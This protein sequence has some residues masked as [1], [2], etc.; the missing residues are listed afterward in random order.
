MV[1][2]PTIDTDTAPSQVVAAA[3]ASSETAAEVERLVAAA[4][5]GDREAVRSLYVRYAGMV[6]GYVHSIVGDRHDAEDVTQQVFTKLLTG[7]GTYE[8]HEGRFSPWILR[9]ARNASIDHLRR[10]REVPA[11]EVRLPCAID[12]GD[13]DRVRSLHESLHSL[14]RTQGQVLILRHLVGLTPGEIATR[15]DRT[16]GS[17]HALQHRAARSLR[18][19]LRRLEAA[20]VPQR[21]A[22]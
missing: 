14:P 12:D 5:E 3:P 11:A 19:M 20:P 2:S 6:H 4:K 17:V 13:R 16:Q 1:Q 10:R 22:G 18:E 7:L 21:R 9:V 8:P 15:L